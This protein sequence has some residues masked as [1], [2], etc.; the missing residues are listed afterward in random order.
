MLTGCTATAGGLAKGEVE[1]PAGVWFSALQRGDKYEVPS[2]AAEGGVKRYP[3]S[4]EVPWNCSYHE[5]CKQ[6]LVSLYLEEQ[7]LDALRFA[8]G[9]RVPF[10]P[11]PLVLDEWDSACFQTTYEEVLKEADRHLHGRCPCHT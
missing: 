3:W 11:S 5:M 6:D 1:V 2:Q 7:P 9:T 10:T 4:F 8:F